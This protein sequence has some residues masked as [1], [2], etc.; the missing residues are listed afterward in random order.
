VVASLVG[1]LVS[2]LGSLDGLRSLWLERPVAWPESF[3]SLPPKAKKA[4]TPR[5][6]TAST[7]TMIPTIG[8]L[9]RLG[10]GGP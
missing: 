10:G 4:P 2:V 5:A 1:L 7:A 8:P 9:P 3:L 6:R